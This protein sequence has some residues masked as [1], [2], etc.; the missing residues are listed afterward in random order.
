[1]ADYVEDFI[2]RH[3]RSTSSKRG[4]K[5]HAVHGLGAGRPPLRRKEAPPT[6]AGGATEGGWKWSKLWRR[7]ARKRRAD[8]SSQ[9]EPVSPSSSSGSGSGSSMAAGA[10]RQAGLPRSAGLK[11]SGSEL[12]ERPSGEWRG[13]Q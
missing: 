8:S 2:Q 13:P 9:A 6:A 12:F 7:W 11:R 3:G 5:M 1:M 10:G 4:L